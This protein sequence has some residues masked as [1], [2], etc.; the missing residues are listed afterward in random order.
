MLFSMMQMLLVTL[1]LAF[2]LR[3]SVTV[4][5]EL[6]DLEIMASHQEGEEWH[7]VFP[8]LSLQSVQAILITCFVV[9]GVL[10]ASIV[11]MQFR[12]VQ[13]GIQW[14]NRQIQSRS[15]DFFA[16]IVCF[17][18]PIIDGLFIYWAREQQELVSDVEPL[19]QKLWPKSVITTCYAICGLS[20][21]SSLIGIIAAHNSAFAQGYLKI[22]LV[23]I[24]L[25]LACIIYQFYTLF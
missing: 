5:G 10:L 14:S 25:L 8:S 15:R 1:I 21:L 23:H 19:Q 3:K 17:V 12:F 9:C 20:V 13:Y 11:S 4:V 22:K 7:T 24:F 16:A 6:R 18:L 2:L